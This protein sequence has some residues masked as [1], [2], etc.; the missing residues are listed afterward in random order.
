MGLRANRAISWIGR[1][2]AC[3]DD[4][5]GARKAG[6]ASDVM[7]WRH[8]V[9]SSGLG[10]MRGDA[11]IAASPVSLP[12]ASLEIGLEVEAGAVES[13]GGGGRAV[14]HEEPWREELVRSRQ[15]GG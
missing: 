9:E 1:G 12:R 7:R 15:V 6:G 13:D 5:D 8:L 2:E 14:V 4:E 3:G 11:A 10:I